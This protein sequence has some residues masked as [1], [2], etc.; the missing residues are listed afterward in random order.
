M[1]INID[2]EPHNADWIRTQAAR[3]KWESPGLAPL[4]GSKAVEPC[5]V[6]AG[7]QDGGRFAP[8]NG[9]S[10]GSAISTP[11][12][13]NWFGDWENDP[14]HASKVV[15][16]DGK[17][18]DTH[19]LENTIPAVVYH[20]TVSGEITEFDKAKQDPTSLYGPG[21]YFTEDKEVAA[22]YAAATRVFE[23]AAT[24]ATVAAQIREQYPAM[25]GFMDNQ[26]DK[27]ESWAVSM[28]TEA[29]NRNYLLGLNPAGLEGLTNEVTKSAIISVHLNIRNPFDADKDSISAS[30][31]GLESWG[32]QKFTYEDLAGIMPKPRAND[33]LKKAGYDGITHIGVDRDKH[34]KKHRVWIAFDPTQIKSSEHN[35]G[36]FDPTNPN[37]NKATNA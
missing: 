31:L 15:G 32:D 30:K 14:K 34:E 8:C 16:K 36:N 26:P 33:L 3:H 37:I 19:P 6:P 4:P 13:K 28:A 17:P 23:L 21:F 22:Q 1:P 7:N 9:G 2:S 25:A 24:P 11:Q 18:K 27:G 5:R 29:A 10:G 12:F 35:D 20:G